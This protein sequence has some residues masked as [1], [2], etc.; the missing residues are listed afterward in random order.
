MMGNTINGVV[1]LSPDK[2][3]VFREVLRVLRPGGRFHLADVIV[4]RELKLE[5][6]SDPDL[7]AACIAGALPEPELFELTAETGFVD[8]QVVARH[9]SFASTPAQSKVS[10]DLHV[11][12]ITFFAR[13]PL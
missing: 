7:W 5:A 9:R 8:R 6:R 11:A 13:K 12:G 4:Q 2:R 10:A 3:Q 1:N